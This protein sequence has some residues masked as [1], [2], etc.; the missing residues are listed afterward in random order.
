MS[1]SPYKVVIYQH[2]PKCGGRSFIKA[3]R[4]HFK[5]VAD[6]PPSY[7]SKEQI[8][9]FAQAKLDLGTLTA[10]SLVHG[11]LVF[12]GI[13]PVERYTEE[14]KQEGFG[15]ITIVRDPLE[16][17]LSAFYHR[18][19]KG[20]AWEAGLEDWLQKRKNN[21]CSF[22]GIKMEGEK[23]IS[24]PFLM[25]GL[26]EQ[27]QDS[28]TVFAN[29]TGMPPVEIERLNTSPRDEVEVPKKT[30]ETFRANNAMDYALHAYAKRR[31]AAQL[32]AV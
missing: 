5:I 30:L 1:R 28:L 17:A 6:Q 13:R 26:T 7:P 23:P 16:R 9:E 2:V 10:P 15:L 29:L 24:D 21:I 20:K 8:Q 3:C 25:M 22:L 11:H 31:L 19:K 4:S 27:L 18:R 14:L 32:E 12:D